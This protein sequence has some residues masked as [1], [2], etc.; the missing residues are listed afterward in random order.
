QQ[1]D[2]LEDGRLE[3]SR[4]VDEVVP[5]DRSFGDEEAD[6]GR[7]PALQAPAR[8]IERQLRTEP[9]VLPGG[10]CLL[11]RGPPR[12]ELRRRAEAVVRLS[13]LQEAQGEG[14]MRLDVARLEKGA[15]VPVD[16]QPAQ[17][18]EDR[19]DALLGRSLLIGVL[20]PQDEG[21][22]VAPGEQPVEQGGPRPPDVQEAGRAR[23]E[24]HPHTTGRGCSGWW[25]RHGSSDLNRSRTGVP[26]VFLIALPPFR[27]Y[28]V[29]QS[30]RRRR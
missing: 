21:A 14:T 6:R 27:R 29:P 16:P 3:R 11:G 22:A 5:R 12:L 25:V 4:P 8:L 15:L 26:S 10:A 7:L 30:T 2:V 9:V 28:M 13:L 18:L 20:D 17:P 24:A 19:P 1:H 23:G